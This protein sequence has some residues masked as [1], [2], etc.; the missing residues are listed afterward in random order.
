[1]SAAASGSMTGSVYVNVFGGPGSGKSTMAYAVAAE[2]KARGYTAECVGEVIKDC[3]YDAARG[4]DEA[5]R[6]LDG[7][8]ESQE[9][10]Y[11]RQSAREHRLDGLVQFV[12]T[13]SP[14]VL[15]LA[16]LAGDADEDR[17]A[18][19]AMLAQDEF[20]AQAS[21]NVIV[22]RDGAYDPRARLHDEAEAARLDADV[23]SLV[24]RVTS[25]RY[26]IV[27]HGDA[28]IVADMAVEYGLNSGRTVGNDELRRALQGAGAGR[29]RGRLGEGASGVAAQPQRVDAG[30]GGSGDARLVPAERSGVDEGQERGPDEPGDGHGAP[31]GR[32]SQDGSRPGMDAGSAALP[33]GGGRRA[34]EGG[35]DERRG[36][37]G[38]R[39][40]DLGDPGHRDNPVARRKPSRR[41][42]KV[43]EGQMSLDLQFEPADAAPAFVAERP[44]PPVP[45]GKPA[46]PAGKQ[47][48][49]ASAKE[50]RPDA[51]KAP[52]SVRARMAQNIEA[53]LVAKGLER[54]GREAAPDERDAM[55]SFVGWGGLAQVFDESSDAWAAEREKLQ[56]GL[57]ERE[58]AKARESTLTAFYTPYE[59]AEAI[60]GYLVSA[61]FHAGRVL[62]PAA[63]TG[64]F[65]DAMPPDLAARTKMTM[66]ELDPVSAL[67]A[68]HAHPGATVQCKGYEA[69]TIAD[70]SYD[71]AVT[72]VPFGQFSVYDRRHAGEG[73]L[74]HD[75]FFA[76]ALDHVR[77]GGLVAF[78]T[79]SGT[80]DKKTSS[81]RRALATRAELVC[82][83]RLP[84][85]TFETS[86]GTTVTSDVVVLKKRA[87]RIP[88]EEAAELS[89]VD[90]VEFADGVRVNRWIAEHE[91]AVLGK[92]EVVS[93][94]YGPQIACKGDWREAAAALAGRLASLAASDYEERKLPAR[95]LGGASDAIEADPSVPDGCYGIVEDGLWFREGELMRPYSGP[96]S[97]EARI[98]SLVNLR[99]LGREYLALQSAGADDE[100]IEDARVAFKAA[101]DRFVAKHGRLNDK[102]NVVAMRGDAHAPLLASWENPVDGA[103]EPAAL[104]TRRTVRP[105]AQQ[106]VA[107]DAAE[108]LAMSLNAKGIVDMGYM[109]SVYGRAPEAILAELAGRVYYDPVQSALVTADEYLSGNVRVKL[110]EARAYRGD[111]DVTANIKAL[112]EVLP[113]DVP[114]EEIALELG[115]TWVPAKVYEQFAYET[116]DLPL[117]H[118][119]EGYREQISVTYSPELSQWRISNKGKVYGTKIDR[120]YGTRD[121]NALELMETSLNLRDEVVKRTVYDPATRKTVSVVDREATIAAQAK[122]DAIAARFR[123]WVWEDGPRRRA[124]VAEYN[125]RFNSLVP[126]VYDG[127]VLSFEGMSA[128]IELEPHQRD[129]AARIVFGGNSLLWYCVGAGKTFTLA[130]ASQELKRLKLASKPLFSV[131][132]HLVGQWG[133]EYM[134]LY[135]QA[136]I[137]VASEEDFSKENRRRFIG[138]IA[139]GDWDAVIISETQ[140]AKI[141][142][143]PELEARYIEEE[144]DRIEDAI[145][146][147]LASDDAAKRLTVKQ[148]EARRKRLE[149]RLEKTRKHDQDDMLSFADLGIDRIFVDEAH[150]YKN[151]FTETK[152]RNVAGLQTG[153]SQRASDMLYKTRYLNE[154]TGYKGVVFATGTAVSN[155]LTE[156]Y[157]MQRYLQ[158]Q[159]LA[160]AGLHGFD[161]WASLFARKTTSLELKPEGSGFHVKTRF[162]S[163][164]NLPELITMFSAVCDVKTAA[165]IDLPG[166]PSARYHNVALEPSPEQVRMVAELGRRADIIRSGSV[167]PA[168]DNMLVVTNDGRKL[169]LDQRLVN[170]DL[171]DSDFS[172]TS[173]AAQAIWSTWKDSEPVRGTQI[174]F[175][176]LSTP[177][178]EGFNVYDDLRDKL[179]GKG[180]PDDQIAFVHDAKTERAKKELF[181]AVRAG[182]VRV[183]MGSTQK[184]GE[185]TN[186]QTRLVALHHL[187]CPWRPSDLEQREGRILRRGNQNAEVDIY[188]YVTKGTFDAYMYQ[189]VENK[190]K[191]IGQVF[192]LGAVTSRTADDIDQTALSYAEVKALCAG[193][194]DVK[195]RLELQN[196]LPRLASLERAH[197]RDQA[198]LRRLCDEVYPATISS[199]ERDIAQLEGDVATMREHKGPAGE[200]PG[201]TVRGVYCDTRSDAADALR[202]ALVACA[203]SSGVTQQIGS[204][205]GLEVTATFRATLGCFSVAVGHAPSMSL[206]G[207]D[208]GIGAVTR[209]ENEAG[210]LERYAAN[211]VARLEQAKRELA[212]ARE[213]L[214]KAFPH[215]RRLLEVK[216]RLAV[217][218]AKI[219]EKGHD[220]SLA[221]VA[222]SNEVGGDQLSLEDSGLIVFD[223]AELIFVNRGIE[224]GW[225]VSVYACAGLDASAMEVASYFATPVLGIG[226]ERG[227]SD[228][229]E[230]ARAIDDGETPYAADAVKEAVKETIR[231]IAAKSERLELSSSDQCQ[232]VE[233][234]GSL[235]LRG[236]R[237][238]ALVKAVASMHGA[239]VAQRNGVGFYG[240]LRNVR[241]AAIAAIDVGDDF[242]RVGT[243]VARAILGTS[244]PSPR[245]AWSVATDVASRAAAAAAKGEGACPM[246]HLLAAGAAGQARAASLS[247][248]VGR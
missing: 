227:R 93:G 80:L 133:I 60:W 39:G 202:S 181:E 146:Q 183:L 163:F 200:F 49:T 18:R 160:L 234:A 47:V 115:A 96:K 206:E 248:G 4:D 36:L 223:R 73:M 85:S 243:E 198:E 29:H 236:A 32:I 46:R 172:K 224:R 188:R 152:M 199:A 61:G 83:A 161:A 30:S 121:R 159:T 195:E 55:L 212:T 110:D 190:Q 98:R 68:K 205:M 129:G 69:T 44:A 11:R 148:L 235:A 41:G 184:L 144:R 192:G 171:P 185:G 246:E 215:Q 167:D 20:D 28:G 136:S 15:G 118:R 37:V 196:E 3:I 7:S 153:D 165:D 5:K 197:R 84:D 77:P 108:A 24:E 186:V 191:F 14:S 226:A 40:H 203:E 53:V 204:F 26:E 59:V 158:P 102:P 125:R 145:E 58:Y 240:V 128:D 150:H 135:P 142:L 231:Y 52:S 45:T 151:L 239:C 217:L 147:A 187:D 134:R 168:S 149:T 117:F 232:L 123:D 238:L 242:V 23:R 31:A 17:A 164:T 175:C 9:E 221:S 220:P 214:G 178:P 177:K 174:V 76:K 62:D 10:L 247:K 233:L 137:L 170:P 72:N 100:P 105:I 141:P 95:E 169:A 241:D 56:A 13:D 106:R 51:D 113:A 104:F 27:G 66:V 208:S 65:A 38:E 103:W 216:Q 63:G 88:K 131:P 111:V 143:P 19:L 124:L 222:E 140:L 107:A 112:E 42:R 94:P 193:D 75:Y 130:A 210:R 67:I 89:W 99:E 54:E 228:W 173:A 81:A 162:S 2:L 119:V 101:Y 244:A 6:L 35:D 194:P 218:D 91:E 22:A 138:R 230:R 74:V 157:N 109:E 90:T 179:V 71:I 21:V 64:R 225:D 87:E 209:I 79:A 176:D 86:A 237:P 43:I 201:M 120:V 92:L 122:Q 156:V 8:V 213:N 229:D 78:I 166:V 245:A 16:Y 154:L 189:T 34:E 116:F 57:T 126:R 219:G 114:A 25:G 48:P 211:A 1:M 82:A 12:V 127:S 180:V 70:E 155:S 182:E 50:I 97:Q 207:A 139:S 33:G 132:K